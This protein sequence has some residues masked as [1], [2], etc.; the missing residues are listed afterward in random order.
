MIKTI[1][2]DWN[3]TLLDDSDCCFEILK[4]SMAKWEIPPIKDKETYKS[5]FRFPVIE[6]YKE[7]GFDCEGEAF[8][9]IAAHYMERY[10][11]RYKDCNL[12]EGAFEVLE[13][14]KSVGIENILLSA[15]KKP[16]LEEQTEFF[17]CQKYFEKR[18][19]IDHIYADS[20]VNLALQWVKESNV[21]PKE[22]LWIGDSTHDLECAE[23]CGVSCILIDHGHQNYERLS[24]T[25][26]PVIRHLREIENL[27]EN[28]Q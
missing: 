13:R 20:K 3:G 19:G 2:W 1:V 21:N 12:H 6:M 10:I 8:K 25:G 22:V 11:E 27:L 15:S 7:L 16:I 17:D 24:R 14:F 18:L 5:I 23:A 26:V 4:E 9:D 28:F